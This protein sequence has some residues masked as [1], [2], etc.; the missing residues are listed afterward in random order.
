MKYSVIIKFSKGKKESLFDSYEDL[1][2]YLSQSRIEDS[3]RYKDFCY[4]WQ[5]MINAIKEGG[6]I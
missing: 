4:L 3:E 1:M 2:K 6:I 5:Y